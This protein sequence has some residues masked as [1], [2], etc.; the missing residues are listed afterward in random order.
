[1]LG[2]IVIGRLYD[3][4]ARWYDAGVA[5]W[6]SID[7]LADEYVSLSAYNYTNNNPIKYIDPNGM[8]F[9]ERSQEHLT[10][11]E[12]EMDSRLKRAN[13]RINNA[14][15]E[16]QKARR[17]RRRDALAASFSEVR[18]EIDELSKSSQGYDIY[19][20]ESMNVN[21]P[22]Q[23]LGANV[24]GTSFD[25]STGMVNILLPKS[26]D[27]GFIAHELKH[28]YQFEKGEYSL[29]PELEGDYSNFLYDRTD[30]ISA[31]KRGS[32]FGQTAHTNNSLPDIY[33]SVA[34]G[35]VDITTHP[36][37]KLILKAPLA[38]QHKAFQERANKTGHAFRVNG[39]TYY[40]KR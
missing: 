21:G 38:R 1:V 9:T 25:N 34:T 22:I 8:Y 20:D 35:P 30:E 6:T 16:N 33:E 32:M 27:I 24:G 7:P 12:E 14:K 23:G 17:T 5:R 11:L 39:E 37:T 10:S 18:K 28:A 4:G 15:N 31:F 2:V 29:G 40:R 36:V 3:Y 26:N 19:L 13:K